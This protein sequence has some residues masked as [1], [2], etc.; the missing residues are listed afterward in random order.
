MNC[1]TTVLSIILVRTGVI[2]IG[3]KSVW[4]FGTCTFGTG[5][6]KAAFHCC[7]TTDVARDR[8][9]SRARG[10]QKTGAPSLRNQKSYRPDKCLFDSERF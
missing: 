3:L 8:L 1:L 2:D 5:H 7:G 9:K 4:S 6:M 10:L